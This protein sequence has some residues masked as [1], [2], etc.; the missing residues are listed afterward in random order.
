MGKDFKSGA[1]SGPKKDFRSGGAAGGAGGFKKS[2]GGGNNSFQRGGPRGGG[3]FNRDQGPPERV[4]P[5]CVFS[6]TCGD[7]I[8]VK[9]LDSKKV[10]KFNRGIYTENKSKVGTVDEIFG[11][12]DGFYY[13][14]KLVEGVSGDSYKPGDKF[15]MGWDDTLPIDRFLPKPKGAAGPRRGPGGPGGFNKGGPGGF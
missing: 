9:S 2:F 5:V 10:P 7:Q 13:S 11:P 14:I 15:C 4:D 1:D 6:H 12:I 3:N 8:I